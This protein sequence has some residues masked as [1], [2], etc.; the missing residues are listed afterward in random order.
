MPTIIGWDWHQT[1]QRLSEQAAIVQRVR[2]IK[3]LYSTTDHALAEQILREYGVA[4]V[5]VGQMERLYYP[6]EGL[7]K[8]A[9]M[10]DR[11]LTR[12]YNNPQVDIYRVTLAAT[13]T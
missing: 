5:Y 10:A 13:T 11:G 9:A 6:Q 2:Q 7:A 12:V 8:F 3:D 1:Q 4:Y